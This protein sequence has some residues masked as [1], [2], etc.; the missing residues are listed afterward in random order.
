M[1]MI[2]FTKLKQQTRF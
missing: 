1:G 2:E